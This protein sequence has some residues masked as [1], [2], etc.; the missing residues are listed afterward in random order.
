[1]TTFDEVKAR[2]SLPTRTVTL[3]LAGE[4]V[5]EIA[6]LELQLAQAKA[7][8]SI[9]EASPRRLIAE[10]IAAKQDQMRE[11]SVD[12]HLRAMGARA[13]STFWASMPERAEG[14]AAR[15]WE[16]RVFPSYAEM[17]SRACVE[18]AMT[19]EQVAELAEVLHASAW[20]KLAGAALAVN[21]G[22]VDV[23]NSAAASELIGNSEQT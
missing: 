11:S 23:P 6:R 16:E 17:V 22:E 8:T 3:C 1:M 15:D 20:N 10:Q 21:S 18:P 19:P 4:L 5:E 2:A 7:P 12:F 14:E 9:G 13:W